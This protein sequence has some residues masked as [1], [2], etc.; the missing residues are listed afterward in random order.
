MYLFEG[1]TK[2]LSSPGSFLKWLQ[3]LEPGASSESLTCVKGPEHLGRVL[4]FS[5]E[6]WRG[7]G[8]GVAGTQTGVCMGCQHCRRQLDVSVGPC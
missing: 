7:A 4:L 1:V 3:L 8:S 2:V 6:D 5:Q